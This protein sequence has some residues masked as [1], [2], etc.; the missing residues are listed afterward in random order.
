MP[1]VPM[2]STLKEKVEG[3]QKILKIWE[4]IS[5]RLPSSY[6]RASI[7]LHMSEEELKEYFFEFYELSSQG[8]SPP[9]AF[10]DAD[11]NTVHVHA[12]MAEFTIKQ[13]AWYLL[14]E[15]G[16]LYAFQKY[17]MNDPRA[18]D[19]NGKLDEL[20]ANRFASRWVRRLHKEGWF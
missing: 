4:K 8:E 1:G 19:E 20:F 11:S 16:H 12:T 9:Y 5:K 10:C 15:V 17:S 2:T 13:V 6:P 3:I 14:H 7:V 18:N